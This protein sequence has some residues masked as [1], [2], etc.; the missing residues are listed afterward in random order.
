MP[1]ARA[2]TWERYNQDFNRGLGR[3]GRWGAAGAAVLA[4]YAAWW[5]RRAY[6]RIYEHTPSIV[7]TQLERGGALPE[8]YT[9]TTYGAARRQ[10]LLAATA[11]PGRA[12][13][14]PPP[15]PPPP[16][17]STGGFSGMYRR[18]YKAPSKRVKSGVYTGRR[19]NFH[20]K[21]IQS[22]G[23][24]GLQLK[25]LSVQAPFNEENLSVIGGD[26]TFGTL[27]PLVL[28]PI[29]GHLTPV[30]LGDG[31]SARISNRIAIKSLL[32]QFEMAFTFRGTV[33]ETYAGPKNVYVEIYLV[34][35]TQTSGSFFQPDEVW[36]SK[37]TNLGAV[38]GNLRN[39]AFV[40]RYR[41]LKTW[42]YVVEMSD[43]GALASD[44]DVNPFSIGS[45]SGEEFYPLQGLVQKYDPANNTGNVAGVIDNSLHLCWNYRFA[46]P[47]SAGTEWRVNTLCNT[48]LRPRYYD[49]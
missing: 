27:L 31:P 33:G 24:L 34:L 32:M 45:C 42:K 16:V 29:E 15:P 13:P 40:S 35:D 43:P 22:G 18:A 8:Y 21:G 9:N 4:P 12:P 49:Q 47:V 7:D 28:D 14:P 46:T 44:D 5:A 11:A 2:G 6:D 20:I 41:V 37:L 36:E 26:Y 17:L 19:K 48:Q 23:L 1:L 10:K 30:A 39:M 38:L 3:F 25:Y